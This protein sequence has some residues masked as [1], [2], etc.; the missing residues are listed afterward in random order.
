MQT[1]KNALVAITLILIGCSGITGCDSL[2]LKNGDNFE[3]SNV[4]PGRF[5]ADDQF[6]HTLAD[7]YVSGGA[8]N[9]DETRYQSNRAYN[10]NYSH[11][12]TARGY[13]SRPYIKNLLPN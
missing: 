2:F 9:L 10:T 6:C 13:R 12:M 8:S 5:E 3:A 7:E 1:R 11:C 4:P